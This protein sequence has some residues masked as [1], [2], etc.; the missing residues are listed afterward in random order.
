MFHVEHYLK[1]T[2]FRSAEKAIECPA[3]HSMAC[4]VNEGRNC[5]ILV[6]SAGRL[7]LTG[8][9]FTGE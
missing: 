6:C 2:Q 7:P 5:V 1:K 9:S 3:F 8:G 4:F